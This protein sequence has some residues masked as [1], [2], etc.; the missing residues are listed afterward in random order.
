[1]PDIIKGEFVTF[2]VCP[3]LMV[4]VVELTE[5]SW[6]CLHVPGGLVH[7]FLIPTTTEQAKLAAWCANQNYKKL[8]SELIPSVRSWLCGYLQAP[9]S[10]DPKQ[11]F[12]KHL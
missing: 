12:F 7:T 3:V 5:L 2:C 10:P 6:Q 9:S 1:M 11:C 4:N 8:P